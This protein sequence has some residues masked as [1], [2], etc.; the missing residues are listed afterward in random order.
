MTTK[1]TTPVRHPES[2]GLLVHDEDTLFRMMYAARGTNPF[3]T[4][5]DDNIES[6]SPGHPDYEDRTKKWVI[7]GISHSGHT[8]SETPINKEYWPSNS[9]SEYLKHYRGAIDRLRQALLGRVK[10]PGTNEWI[11]L[12]YA[13]HH[14]RFPLYEWKLI[15]VGVPVV[16]IQPDLRSSFLN[17]RPIDGRITTPIL[18]H[19]VPN[20][21]DKDA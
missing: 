10:I 6:F 3:P 20:V 18:Y 2:S 16:Y 5:P 17:H 19:L 4:H 1:E 12:L 15:D 9:R 7:H 21:D 11:D 8:F 14:D 13:R